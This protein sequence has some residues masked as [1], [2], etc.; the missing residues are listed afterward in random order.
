MTLSVSF[1]KPGPSLLFAFAQG[2]FA[3]LLHESSARAFPL[4]FGQVCSRIP[5]LHAL[6]VHCSNAGPHINRGCAFR[7]QIG[8]A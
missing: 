3:A 4:L 1:S 7:P 2:G 5:I 8:W 6:R